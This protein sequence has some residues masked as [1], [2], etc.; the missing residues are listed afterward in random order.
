M[1]SGIFIE[2]D[3][4]FLVRKYLDSKRKWLLAKNRGMRVLIPKII[5]R[6][7]S[8]DVVSHHILDKDGIKDILPWKSVGMG[9]KEFSAPRGGD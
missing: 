6:D 7:C 5:K 9:I 8:T 4:Q 2:E 1:L 3:T